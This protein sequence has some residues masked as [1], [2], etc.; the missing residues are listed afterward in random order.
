MTAVLDS[1]T[2]TVY[3]PVAGRLVMERPVN[4]LETLENGT[5][6]LFCNSKPNAQVLL[7]AVADEMTHLIPTLRVARS[8]KALPTRAAPSEVYEYLVRSCDA[9][10][11]ASADC[12]SCT[13]WGLYDVAEI[14][15]RG[16][17]AVCLVAHPFVPM[18][19]AQAR[20]MQHPDL[21]FV[22]F[23]GPIAGVPTE[24]VREKGVA[25]SPSVIEVLTEAM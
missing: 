1:E 25:L 13:S 17:P 8:S 21:R 14:E 9:V 3:S 18:V 7:D 24:T 10:I 20:A 16:V 4:R 11:F 22:V 5:I 15:K 19:Q 12:G 6:G 23:D 2:L